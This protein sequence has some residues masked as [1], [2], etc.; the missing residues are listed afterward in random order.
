MVQQKNSKTL[1][2]FSLFAIL[3][4]TSFALGGCTDDQSTV[5]SKFIP[6]NERFTMFANQTFSVDAYTVVQDSILTDQAGI[7]PL[8]SMTNPFLGR[9]RTAITTELYPYYKDTMLDNS[10]NTRVLDYVELQLVVSNYIGDKS[11]SI[12]VLMHELTQNLDTTKTYYSNAEV[13]T[14]KSE[15]IASFTLD[16]VKTKLIRFNGALATQLGNDLIDAATSKQIYDINYFRTKFKGFCLLV[17]PTETD[18]AFYKINLATSQI[19]VHYFVTHKLANGT[20]KKDTTSLP[21]YFANKRVYGSASNAQPG[22]TKRFVSIKHDKTTAVNSIAPKNVGTTTKDTVFYSSTMGGE[23]GFIN[24]DK[25][26]SWKDS[27]AAIFHRVELQVEYLKTGDTE[28]DRIPK[29]FGLFTKDSA[30]YYTPVF[31]LQLESSSGDFTGTYDANFR[32]GRMSYSANITRYFQKMI[33]EG[34]M[35]HLYLVPITTDQKP[36]NTNTSFF[37]DYSYGVFRGSTSASPVKLVITY[38]KLKN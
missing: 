35:S 11:K 7:A 38:S 16:S 21:F 33:K 24:L 27:T 30:G 26:L 17:D 5:G 19:L 10:A 4:I 9:T 1:S 2:A 25:Y 22:V 8:G 34:K 13:P 29:K 28:M 15:A 12:K 3:V 14:Y 31:D 32:K 37:E 23:I 20:L 6:D 18:G 36:T